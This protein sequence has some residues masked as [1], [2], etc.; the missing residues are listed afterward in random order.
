VHFH[1]VRISSLGSFRSRAIVWVHCSNRKC[2][3]HVSLRTGFDLV[4]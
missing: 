1:N 3:T 2:V 4:I